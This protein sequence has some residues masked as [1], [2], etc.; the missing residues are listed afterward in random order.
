MPA[1][2][3]SDNR[4]KLSN[5]PR[6]FPRASGNRMHGVRRKCH[7]RRTPQTF[8]QCSNSPLKAG[9]DPN[10][11]HPAVR[12]DRL[13]AFV[14]DVLRQQVFESNAAERVK[15]AIVRAKARKATQVSADEKRLRAVRQKIERG[16]ENL[17]LASREDFSAISKLL[18]KWREEEAELADRI[19]R[20][21]GELEPLPEALDV[22]AHFADLGKKLKQ[23]DRVKLA[24]AVKQTVVSI[25]IGT[26]LATTGEI[27]HREHFGELRLHEALHKKPIA[28]PDEAIGQ[29]KVWR[30]F[31]ELVRN[32]D[33]PLHL[34]DFANHIGTADLSHAAHH[35]RRAEKAGLIR[36]LGHQG[37]WTAD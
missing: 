18:M 7:D 33:H 34:A 19:E 5:P 20:R 2:E 22:I 1:A 6:L 30:E 37:G 25:A 12:V 21:N 26:R 14:L 8:Y 28:I 15:D 24:H 3:N 13:E 23:A 10:C 36:K 27:Q 4:K 16:S 32:A 17:A 11:P 9:N 29:R 35:V 31:G